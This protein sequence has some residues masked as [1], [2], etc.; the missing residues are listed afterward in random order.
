M[1]YYLAGPMSGIEEQNYPAFVSACQ[2]LR[3]AGFNVLS[4][5]ESLPH[6]TQPDEAGWAELLRHDTRSLLSCG[7]IILLPGWTKSK[8]ARFEVNIALTLGMEIYLF[9][10]GMLFDIA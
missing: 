9:K 6:P 8:G 3:Y 2:Q 5:H 4:P 1:N 7:G 10:E